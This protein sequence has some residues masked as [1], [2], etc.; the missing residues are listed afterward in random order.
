MA[1]RHWVLVDMVLELIKKDKLNQNPLDDLEDV[2]LIKAVENFKVEVVIH[3]D[4]NLFFL[5]KE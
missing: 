5:Q 4:K 2:C 1:N 3:K